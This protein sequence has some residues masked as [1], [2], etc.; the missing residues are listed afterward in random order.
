MSLLR[1]LP[2]SIKAPVRLSII[3]I[4][5]GVCIAMTILSGACFNILR[6]MLIFVD[7]IRINHSGYGFITYY[8]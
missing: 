2:F 6:M 8:V 3:F 5:A 4:Y 7:L 1:V